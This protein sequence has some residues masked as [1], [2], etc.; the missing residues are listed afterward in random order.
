MTKASLFGNAEKSSLKFIFKWI[1][2]AVLIPPNAYPELM[3]P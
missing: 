1:I 2:Q 3:R